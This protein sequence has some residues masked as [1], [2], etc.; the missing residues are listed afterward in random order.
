[1]FYLKMHFHILSSFQF[2]VITLTGRLLYTDGKH[3][4]DSMAFDEIGAKQT[5]AI[6]WGKGWT[7]KLP[8]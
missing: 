2:N 5:F 1:M 3:V 7:R 6:K 4:N 8:S